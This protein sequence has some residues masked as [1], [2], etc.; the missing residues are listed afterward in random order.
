MP[1]ELHFLHFLDSQKMLVDRINHCGIIQK[2]QQ[3]SRLQISSIVSNNNH[4]HVLVGQQPKQLLQAD[5]L[6][7]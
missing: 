6:H 7:L 3:G 5:V 4:V 2:L 1:R